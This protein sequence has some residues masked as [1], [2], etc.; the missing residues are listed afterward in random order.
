MPSSQ[1]EGGGERNEKL[2]MKMKDVMWDESICDGSIWMW[3]KILRR[4]S[5]MKILMMTT[6][7]NDRRTRNAREMRGGS[8]FLAKMGEGVSVARPK[9]RSYWLRAA[10]LLLANPIPLSFSFGDHAV[11]ERKKNGD[12]PFW[13]TEVLRVEPFPRND[14]KAFV[15]ESSEKARIAENIPTTTLRTSELTIQRVWG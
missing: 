1:C 13:A 7:S 4:L 2:T 3:L 11:A 15:S 6:D 12:E 14:V 5:Q 10:P 9:K 8:G